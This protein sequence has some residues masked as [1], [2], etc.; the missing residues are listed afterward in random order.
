MG[1]IQWENWFC[2]L[3]LSLNLTTEVSQEHLFPHGRGW[4][5]RWADLYACSLMHA[6][7]VIRIQESRSERKELYQLKA[8]CRH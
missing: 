3:H 2:Q 5:Q 6:S 1:T 7:K 8:R 4:N